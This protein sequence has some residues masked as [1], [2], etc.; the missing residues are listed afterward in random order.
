L[1][2]FPNARYVVQRQ[3]LE[4]ATHPHERSRASYLPENIGPVLEAGL[5][6]AVEGETELLR[7]LRLV[8]VPGHT[9]GM[10]AVELESEGQR[11]AFT[12]DLIP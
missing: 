3:E 10:Q 1:P 6:E 12:A 7:G 2:T 4:E 9:L 5:F 8:P 11:L